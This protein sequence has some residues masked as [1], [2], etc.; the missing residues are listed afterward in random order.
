MRVPASALIAMVALSTTSFA[1]E[2]IIE[3]IA[4]N[5][6]QGNGGEG[7]PARAAELDNPFG[8]VRGPDGA[9]WFT[10]FSGQ[11]IRRIDRRGKIETMAGT[12]AAGYGGDGGSSSRWSSYHCGLHASHR[13]R[14]IVFCPATITFLCSDG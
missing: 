13:P 12:G 4:G 14:A 9:I 8:V 10:E 7:G 2:W 6:E 3:T 1:S 5:G 11:R